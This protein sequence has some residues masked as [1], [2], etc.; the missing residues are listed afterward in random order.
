MTG[1]PPSDALRRQLEANPEP[2]MA[3]MTTEH[4]TLAGAQSQTITEAN[5]RASIFLAAVTSGLISLGFLGPSG[6]TF[7]IL[8]LVLFPT[9]ALL[10]L[11]TFKRVLQNSVENL[12]YAYRIDLCRRFY[13][14][15]WPMLTP[16][17]YRPGV[18]EDAPRTLGWQLFLTVSGVVAML[19]GLLLGTSS[20]LLTRV[21]A[22]S[23]IGVA[24]AVGAVI[25]A[26]CVL[27]LHRQQRRA[28]ARADFGRI[29]AQMHR[30]DRASRP[31]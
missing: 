29:D 21:L 18:D 8:A 4:F 27:A 12:A 2:L 5:G 16:Y 22:G 10:G 6:T 28:F 3:A 13:V 11:M 7:E 19:T 31:R 15:A 24:F 17:L 20:A 1:P 23:S 9:L 26:T 14:E 25:A 30:L